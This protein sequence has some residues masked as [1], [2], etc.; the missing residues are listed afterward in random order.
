MAHTKAPRVYYVTTPLS[1]AVF[2]KQKKKTNFNTK[3]NS[4]GAGKTDQWLRLLIVLSEIQ[5]LVSST[6]AGNSNPPITSGST[7]TT[8]SSG[9]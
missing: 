7:D 5:S 4:S 3:I 6:Q 1:A 8:S 2:Q 9:L